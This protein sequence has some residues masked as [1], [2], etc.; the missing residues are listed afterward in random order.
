MSNS[1]EFA[2]N[3]SEI[4]KKDCKACMERENIK[5]EC[6]CV[7]FKNNKLN[8]KCKECIKRRFKSVTD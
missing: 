2:D 4:N 7:E 6:N 8:Y 1:S 5:S 3:L